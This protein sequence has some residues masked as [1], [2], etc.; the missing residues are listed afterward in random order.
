M[1]TVD[2][3]RQIYFKGDSK[4]LNREELDTLQAWHESEDHQ[5]KG[6]WNGSCFC[7]CELCPPEYK[8]EEDG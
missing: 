7:C 5:S 3:L 1:K 6:V 4:T 2:E 8:E